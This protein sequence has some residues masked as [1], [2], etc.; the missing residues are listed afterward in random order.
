MWR[1]LLSAHRR[2][3]LGDWRSGPGLC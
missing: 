2:I 3:P 1:R